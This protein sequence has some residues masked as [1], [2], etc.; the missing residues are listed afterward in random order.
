[1]VEQLQEWAGWWRQYQ[2]AAAETTAGWAS[3][4]CIF[5]G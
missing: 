4:E 2:F 3:C 5:Q 1:V